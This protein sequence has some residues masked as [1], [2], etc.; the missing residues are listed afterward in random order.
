MSIDSKDPRWKSAEASVK[1]ADYDPG[2]DPHSLKAFTSEIQMGIKRAMEEATSNPNM[3]WQSGMDADALVV[4][5]AEEVIDLL[6]RTVLAAKSSGG[7]RI[8]TPQRYA[9]KLSGSLSKM[10]YNLGRSEGYKSV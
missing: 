4:M 7:A 8:A 10:L 3:A 2:P 5:G 1:S 9:A 6:K